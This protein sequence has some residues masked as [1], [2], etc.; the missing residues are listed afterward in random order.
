[1]PHMDTNETQ[2]REKAWWELLKNAVYFLEKN[3]GSIIVQSS[4][5]AT[6]F[7]SHQP[8]K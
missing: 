8:P 4:C 1:M 3:T 5:T 2:K 7:L 6:C